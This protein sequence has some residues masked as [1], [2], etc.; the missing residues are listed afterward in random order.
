MFVSK[1]RP[2]IIAFQNLRQTN[3]ATAQR[4]IYDADNGMTKV[5]VLGTSLA[6]RLDS[7]LLEKEIYNL[8]LGGDSAITG[9]EMVVRKGSHVPFVA[10]ETN[11]LLMKEKNQDLLNE[12]FYPY[13]WK[14]RKYVPSLREEY[15]PVNMLLSFLVRCVSGNI[16]QRE[17]TIGNEKTVQRMLM[18]AKENSKKETL[19]MKVVEKNY[20]DLRRLIGILKDK[21]SKIIF[22][23]MPIHPEM[24]TL[25]PY[26]ENNELMRKHFSGPEYI[27]LDI[28][29]DQGYLTTDGL[30]LRYESAHVFTT[31]FVNNLKREII[32]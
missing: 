8:S 31:G 27:W 22:F 24:I 11:L 17:N 12:I 16:E 9:L 30:H 13:L 25:T 4:Y 7:A 32:N 28:P 2:Q 3:K 6:S 5:V 20:E 14:V 29:S 10:I 26:R 18:L 1:A 19:N 15:Q 23:T 21:G